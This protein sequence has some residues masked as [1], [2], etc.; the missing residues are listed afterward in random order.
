MLCVAPTAASL[1]S[2]ALDFT[3]YAPSLNNLSI[4]TLLVSALPVLEVDT[5]ERLPELPPLSAG[6][7]PFKILAAALL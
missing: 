6:F 2:N 3:S 5:L 1:K 4:G 7:L